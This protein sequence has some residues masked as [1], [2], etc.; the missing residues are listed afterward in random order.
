MALQ[1][2]GT[3]TVVAVDIDVG[4]PRSVL[5]AW[6]LLNVGMMACQVVSETKTPRQRGFERGVPRTGSQV[7]VAV[8]G[9]AKSDSPAPPEGTITSL[10]S[11]VLG[12]TDR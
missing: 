11:N 5:T 6:R 12:R 4:R 2:L 7:R 1:V 3:P 9:E 10:H 8:G